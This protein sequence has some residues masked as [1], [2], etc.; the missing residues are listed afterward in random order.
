MSKH[1]IDLTGEE[2]DVKEKFG[3]ATGDLYTH[4]RGGSEYVARRHKITVE[5]E[6]TLSPEEVA[7]VITGMSI[8]NFAEVLHHLHERTQCWGT[9][10]RVH[11]WGQLGAY[12][13][14][15]EENHGYEFVR[16]LERWLRP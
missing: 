10:N 9:K 5:A 15:H 8:E 1:A 12:M 14:E 6:V 11:L 3:E 16:E 4:T 2:H 7:K 13:E